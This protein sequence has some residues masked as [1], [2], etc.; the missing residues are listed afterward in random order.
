MLKKTTWLRLFAI[1][2]LA[3]FISP[4]TF[5]QSKLGDMDVDQTAT[6]AIRAATTAPEYLTE[7]VGSLP[8]SDTVPSP[9]ATCWLLPLPILKYSRI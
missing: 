2:T 1:G 8:Q 4:S 6:D 7:W 3:L 5:A 9:P